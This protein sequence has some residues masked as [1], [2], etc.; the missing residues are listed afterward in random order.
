MPSACS[1]MN[2]YFS[3]VTGTCFKKYSSTLTWDLAHESCQSATAQ[4]PGLRGRLAHI[5]SD[6][7]WSD[8]VNNAA[9]AVTIGD[10]DSWIGLRDISLNCGLWNWKVCWGWME[11][12]VSDLKSS[13]CLDQSFEPSAGWNIPTPTRQCLLVLT[14]GT[15]QHEYCSESKAYICEFVEGLFS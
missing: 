9:P 12:L 15:W 10:G 4:I 5:S 2:G 7:I 14:D 13:G 11:G 1:S 6:T 3:A 8:I